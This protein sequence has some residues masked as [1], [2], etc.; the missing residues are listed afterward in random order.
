M[1]PSPHLLVLSLFGFVATGLSQVLAAQAAPV[2]GKASLPATAGKRTAVSSKKAEPAVSFEAD[3]RPILKAYCFD[4]HGG[5]EKLEA[6]LDLRLRRFLVR[7]GDSG[8]AIV[9]GKPD[10]SLLLRRLKSGEM[11]PTTKKVPEDKIAVIE[12][13]IAAGAPTRRV[14]PAQLPAGMDITPDERAYWFY[15]PVRTP[16]PPVFRAADRVRTP[17][18]AFVLRRLREKGLT[19]APDADRL[20]LIRR[21]A[22]DLTGIP[23]S[24]AEVA[25]FVNDGSTDAYER[26]VDH[27]LASPAYGERWGR[28]W[29]D[30]AGYADSEGNGT[31]DTPRPYA[32]KYRDYVIRAMNADKPID[33]FI[34]EQL[35]GDEL[36]P[37]PWNN[38]K[39]EQIEKLTATG[40]LRTAVDG[41]ASGNDLATSNQVVTDTIKIVSSSLLG[42]TVGCAQCHDHRYDP[43][44]QADYYR[45]RAIFEPALSPEHWLTPGQRLISLYTDEQRKRAAEVE[46]E[47][48]KLQAA[49]N[50]KQDR[51]VAAAVE[52]ELGQFPPE[53]REKL[54]AA[55]SAPAEKRTPE[56]KL[57]VANNPKLLISPGVLYQYNEAASNELKADQAKIQAKRAERPVEDFV[58]VLTEVPGQVP[59]THLF[60]RGDYRQP[61]QAILPG[62]LTIAAPE[63]ARLELPEK[64]PNLATSGRRLSWARHLVD[65]RHPL[66][67]RVLVN[68]V[69]LGHFGRGLVDTPGDFGNLGR[70]PTHPDLLDW[71]ASEFVG[72]ASPAEPGQGVRVREREGVRPVV[73]ERSVPTPTSGLQT[74]AGLG[75]SLKR[76]HRLILLSTVYRQASVATGKKRVVDSDGSLYSRF[77]VQRLDAEALRDRMLVAAGR[78][79]LTP[80]GPPVPIVEDNVGQVA[81]KD[82]APR[83]SIY[84]QVR[85]SRPVSFLTAFDAPVMTVNCERRI[86]SNSAPQA[87]ML[88]NSDFVVTQASHFAQ[89]L[90]KEAPEGLR[91]QVQ[92]AWSI[93]YGRPAT[94]DETEAA[95]RFVQKQT[96]RQRAALGAEKADVA[97][98]TDLCQQ[99]LSSNEFLY[100]D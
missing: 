65:G 5:G 61:K 7:G 67:G 95:L 62:D 36:V 13:W 21:V 10:Q 16:Q 9:P 14:E 88:M 17:I 72:T 19:F 75:W 52:K 28:H 76:L 91:Q 78:L 92:L 34:I 27:F 46:A 79:D 83:R 43:I 84:L 60:Y 80:F 54:R 50:E 57:L 12:R 3:V 55:L 26:M 64:D 45:M 39:P 86:S 69:W 63:G 51:F 25:Q 66:V 1:R 24:A 2:S 37:R 41:T 6:K 56:Q 15:Q 8:H 93:A 58:S 20:T 53:L 100:V 48:Q 98:L 94:A 81:A 73:Q 38:L 90:R 68:R 82:D 42:L 96:D 77:P 29:L 30:V 85:R 49:Y 44:P 40:F 11:P 59:V 32:Y 4:C 18:D 33:Q 23:P 99:L 74:T 97:A 70:K 87:L 47:A 89:R 31:D 71:L 35:A 22:L